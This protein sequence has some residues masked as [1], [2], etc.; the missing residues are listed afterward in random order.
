[1]QVISLSWISVALNST[2]LW[3]FAL[4][5]V[6]LWSANNYQRGELENTSEICTPGIE[7]QT[8][9]SDCSPKHTVDEFYPWW[10][11]RSKTCCLLPASFSENSILLL[12][13]MKTFGVILDPTDSP[14]PKLPANSSGSAFKILAEFYPNP[15]PPQHNYPRTDR[16][17][18]SPTVSNLHI[19]PLHLS[20]T[21]SQNDSFNTKVTP[22]HCSAWKSS[23]DSPW[24]SISHTVKSKVLTRSARLHLAYPLPLWPH[25]VPLFTR[26]NL[27]PTHWAG[28][29]LR[30]PVI[31]TA[32][33]RSLVSGLW[34]MSSN[35]E[36]FPD[37]PA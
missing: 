15:P 37:Q 9:I 12:S 16:H 23:K 3:N 11:P 27:I 21:H 22:R 32:L 25:L 36:T 2:T 29:H 8:H 5:G 30:A 13:Q 33:S 10:C 14:A 26:N 31:C 35:R 34:T 1:M 19:R 18:C 6:F 28:S 4:T 17:H 7:F 24:V 20:F